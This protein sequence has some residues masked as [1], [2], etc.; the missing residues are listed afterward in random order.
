MRGTMHKRAVAGN[1]HYAKSS[2]PAQRRWQ[3]ARA[4]S[5]YGTDG[6]TMRK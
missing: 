4:L 6:V 1:H 2:V 5:V 3:I